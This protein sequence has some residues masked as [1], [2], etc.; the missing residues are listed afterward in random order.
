MGKTCK[1]AGAHRGLV[2]VWLQ[3]AHEVQ[4]LQHLI[5]LP[6]ALL[7]AAGSAEEGVLLVISYLLPVALLQQ[8]IAQH[9]YLHSHCPSP[10]KSSS[11][12]MNKPLE[13]ICGLTM[14][15]VQ[16][17]KILFPRNSLYGL[18][19][20]ICLLHELHGKTCMLRAKYVAQGMHGRSS[21]LE[22]CC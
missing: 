12:V 3:V 2:L 11:A 22:S 19:I 17:G 1:A 8:S 13:S 10:C 18:H 5:H 16:A 15:W 6:L 4:C 7:C 20:L 14:R 21:N 9:R